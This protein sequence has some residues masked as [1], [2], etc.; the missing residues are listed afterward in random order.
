MS[1]SDCRISSF[2]GFNTPKVGANDDEHFMGAPVLGVEEVDALDG[3]DE[4]SEESDED[5]AEEGE[6]SNVEQQ[7]DTAGGAVE[8]EKG[9]SDSDESEDDEESGK[10]TRQTCHFSRLLI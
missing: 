7:D 9:D 6:G 10:T 2:T 1:F 8:S 5:N 4:E 3:L